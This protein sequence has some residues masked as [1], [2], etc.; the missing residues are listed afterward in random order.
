MQGSGRT[1]SGVHALC[2]VA[3]LDANTMLAP[4]I[5][6]MKLNDLLPHDINILEVEKASTKLSRKARCESHAAMFIRFQNEELLLVKILS[7]G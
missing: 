7:G 1:D 6:R 3:H 5:I 4:E 2:Q